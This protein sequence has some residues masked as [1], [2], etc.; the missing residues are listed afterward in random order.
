M[1]ALVPIVVLVAVLGLMLGCTDFAGAAE[2]LA[3][4]APTSGA[5]ARNAAPNVVQLNAEHPA[6]MNANA[7]RPAPAKGA[8]ASEGKH[9]NHASFLNAAAA[10][11]GTGQASAQAPSP[12]PAMAPTSAAAAATKPFIAPSTPAVPPEA[13]EAAQSS[14]AGHSQYLHKLH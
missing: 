7:V 9:L 3:K 10:R 11:P 1:R 6:E 13:A 12:P 8:D 5:A 14:S 2:P 4:S